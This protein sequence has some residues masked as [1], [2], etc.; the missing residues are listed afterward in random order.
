MD[1]ILDEDMS[2]CERAMDCVKLLEQMS[3]KVDTET[4]WMKEKEEKVS[5]EEQ[6]SFMMEHN[7]W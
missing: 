5:H 4:T 2:L 1:T 6:R 7:F 3:I